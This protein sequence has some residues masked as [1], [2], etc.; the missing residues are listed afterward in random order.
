MSKLN[1]VLNKIRCDH[2]APAPPIAPDDPIAD[3]LIYA[4]FS[5]P[6]RESMRIAAKRFSWGPEDWR[7]QTVMI[8]DAMLGGWYDADE[9]AAAYRDAPARQEAA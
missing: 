7:L 2:D 4:S 8:Q 9:I 6:L 5:Q 3:R 1:A